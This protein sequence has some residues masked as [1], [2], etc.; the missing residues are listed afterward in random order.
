[1]TLVHSSWLPFRQDL[2]CPGFLFQMHCWNVVSWY[3]KCNT[4]AWEMY[5]N[6]SVL[7]WKIE[8]GRDFC[9]FFHMA[10]APLPDS[11]FFLWA[12]WS[13]EYFFRAAT[14]AFLLRTCSVHGWIG[15]SPYLRVQFRR[16]RWLWT[17]RRKCCCSLRYS[18]P[19][20]EWE[21]ERL[22]KAG[23]SKRCE[24]GVKD[25]I[26]TGFLIKYVP[27]ISYATPQLY[28]HVFF[29]TPLSFSREMELENVKIY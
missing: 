29:C 21:K 6:L 22:G 12:P 1:M 20:T 23:S 24:W 26:L 27:I 25:E 3:C 13:P 14:A 11:H 2:K 28:W 5:S 10:A 17:A 7:S 9:Q 4:S 8:K 15:N 16:K 18:V 19:S